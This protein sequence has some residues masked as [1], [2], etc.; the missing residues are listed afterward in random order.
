MDNFIKGVFAGGLIICL[1]MLNFQ[2]P[3][4]CQ[5][6]LTRG[7]VTTVSIGDYDE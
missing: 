7:N 6:S 4:K 2:Q 3:K 5:I 1:L